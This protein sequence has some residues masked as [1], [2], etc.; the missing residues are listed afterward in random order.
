LHKI[1]R[2]GKLQ[3]EN[4]WEAGI[5][6]MEKKKIMVVDDQPSV[7]TG[8]VGILK[9]DYNVFPFTSGKDAL[10][11]LTTN[12]IDLVLLDYEMPEMTGYEVLINIRMNRLTKETPVV[13]LTGQT[14]ERMRQEMISRGANDYLCKPVNPDELHACIKK[15]L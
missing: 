5:E 7:C 2:C 10:D 8:V 4:E 1:L 13:F 14:N 3:T 12:M 15:Y 11:F 9:F 6:Y